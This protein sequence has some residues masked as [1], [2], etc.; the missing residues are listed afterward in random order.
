MESEPRKPSPDTAPQPD[1]RSGTPVPGQLGAEFG[2]SS[3]GIFLAVSIA[4]GAFIGYQADRLF[5]TK[6]WLFLVFLLSGIIAGFRNIF[7]ELRRLEAINRRAA[8][9][10]DAQRDD[11]SA[12]GDAR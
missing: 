8:Q 7:R 10:R 9:Q 1:R 4:L 6:P 2:L 12:D 11:E 3:I 5:G